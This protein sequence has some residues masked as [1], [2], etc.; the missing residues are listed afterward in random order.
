M[1]H[2][3]RC[4]LHKGGPPARRASLVDEDN[5]GDEIRTD[6]WVVQC[7]TN[8]H[9]CSQPRDRGLRTILPVDGP[10]RV[11]EVPDETTILQEDDPPRDMINALDGTGHRRA[12]RASRIGAGKREETRE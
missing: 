11:D 10:F 9:T 6:E 1:E 2:R 12:P 5:P 3:H 4:R 8:S 7:R